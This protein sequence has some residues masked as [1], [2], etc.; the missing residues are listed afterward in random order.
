MARAKTPLPR[1]E[2]LEK[3]LRVRMLPEDF[4]RLARVATK[5]KKTNSD[6]ARDALEI[7]L[8]KAERELGLR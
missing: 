5:K 1:R 3:T 6:I 2:P 8:A 7:Y 4:Y